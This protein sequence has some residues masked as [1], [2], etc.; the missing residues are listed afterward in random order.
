MP[1]AIKTSPHTPWTLR[2]TADY[3][4]YDKIEDWLKNPPSASK[5]PD[6]LFRISLGIYV[7]GYEK[8]SKDG[9]PAT[10]HYHI[11]LESNASR[12][13]IAD[14]VRSLG[15]SNK[16]SLSTVKSGQFLDID[17]I[18]YCIKQGDYRHSVSISDELLKEAKIAV[19]AYINRKPVKEKT[20]VDLIASHY[21]YDEP[22]NAPCC[23]SQIVEDVIS[24]WAKERRSVR[25]HMMTSTAGTL[26]L[27]YCQEETSGCLRD[28]I[29]QSFSVNMR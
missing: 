8:K 21:K 2:I 14:A 11:Y 25:L 12:Q 22:G 15:Y 19:E 9:S 4:D 13:R 26:G 24:F 1:R 17:Y 5:D 6:S 29:I 23:L 28:K 7:I 20:V 10:P 16:Y 27:R 3:S 18:A